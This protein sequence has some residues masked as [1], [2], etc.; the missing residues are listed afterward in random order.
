M[1]A[2]KFGVSATFA[3]IWIYAAELFPTVVRTNALRIILKIIV[4][5]VHNMYHA[6]AYVTDMS[7]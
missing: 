3:V 6:I 4:C 2:G 7:M 1:L 5:T